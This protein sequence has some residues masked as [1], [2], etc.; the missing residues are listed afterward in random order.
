MGKNKVDI[1]NGITPPKKSHKRLKAPFAWV[2]GKNKL[3]PKIVELMPP[4]ESYIEVFGG[5]LSVFYHKE[6]SKIEII[7]DINS[8]LINLHNIIKTRPLSLADELGGM[9]MSRELFDD[10]K[11]GRLKPRNRLQKS[12]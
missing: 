2:G 9:L 10:I 7:N 6:P 8:D 11:N 4:H 5:A 3:A 1:V 12:L